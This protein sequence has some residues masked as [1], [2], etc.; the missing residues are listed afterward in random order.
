MYAIE[1]KQL[2][3]KYG[4]K[5]AVDQMDLQVKQGSIFGFLGKNGAGKSTFINMVTG[6]IQPSSGSFTL[7]GEDYYSKRETFRRIGVLPEYA[8]LYEDMSAINHLKYFSSILGLS[9]SYSDMLHLLKQVGL[10]DAAKLK[11]KKYSFGMKKKLG[12][13]QAIMNKPDILILDEP[14]SGIDANAVL[15]MHTLIQHISSNGTTVFLTSHNLDEVEK[16][17]DEVAIMNQGT[18]QL[19]GSMEE[20]RKQY[21]DNLRVYVRHPNLTEAQAVALDETL[22]PLG[23]EVAFHEKYSEI[24]VNDEMTIPAINRTFV[25]LGIDVYRLEVE[26]ASL[27]EIFLNT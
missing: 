2:T 11:V 15:S 9:L 18:I 24:T 1:T 8:T 20:L 19:Q 13:A 17:C 26:E 22:Q 5:T 6:L 27:E 3:K 4:V 25:D 23:V 16:I 10:E 12:M 14:T 21:Q 7:L